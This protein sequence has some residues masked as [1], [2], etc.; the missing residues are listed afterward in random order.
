MTLCEVDFSH[1]RIGYQGTRYIVDALNRNVYIRQFNFA[2][3]EMGS[4][5][6]EFSI[7][8][9]SVLTRHPSIL[10][11]DITHTGLK[12]EEVL[13]VGL[14]L[15]MSKTVLSVHLTA[16]ELPYYDRV[17]LRAVIAARVGY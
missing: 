6:Y 10:H 15:S 8:I 2:F 11:M 1:C 3:N 16:N 5:K 9:A 17:F 12:R 7:K 14:A 13:F 4:S